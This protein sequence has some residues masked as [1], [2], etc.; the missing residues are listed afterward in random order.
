[1]YTSKNNFKKSFRPNRQPAQPAPQ[2]QKDKVSFLA[3]GC[4]EIQQAVEEF[5]NQMPDKADELLT[6]LFQ[7]FEVHVKQ[8]FKNG[9]EVG[10]KR[11]KKANPWTK[12]KKEQ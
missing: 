6:A 4:M 8:S 9:I 10:E 2:E 7:I 5:A 12:M 1:M 3:S 11:A